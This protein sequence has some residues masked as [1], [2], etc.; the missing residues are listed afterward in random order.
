MNARTYNPEPVFAALKAQRLRLPDERLEAWREAITNGTFSA[1]LARANSLPFAVSVQVL[2]GPVALTRTKPDTGH[3]TIAWV[4]PATAAAAGA[5]GLELGHQS[6]SIS[7]FLV[8]GT[9]MALD[10][11]IISYINTSDDAPKRGPHRPR[12][13]NLVLVPESL[14]QT[15]AVSRAMRHLFPI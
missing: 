1:S 4:L 7:M 11:G 14:L 10:N 5:A 8:H 2:S 15:P 13:I 3:Q 6:N 12:T 9:Q